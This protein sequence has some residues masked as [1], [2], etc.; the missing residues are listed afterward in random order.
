MIRSTGPPRAPQ[1]ESNSNA[2]EKHGD[3]LQLNLGR[4]LPPLANNAVDIQFCLAFFVEHPK[5]CFGYPKN[6]LHVRNLSLT[7][8]F[9][10]NSDASFRHRFQSI[11]RNET[12]TNGYEPSETNEAKRT[13]GGVCAR[14]AKRPRIGGFTCPS[15]CFVCFVSFLDIQRNAGHTLELS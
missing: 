10:S 2:K 8:E 7:F 12:K 6:V 9:K 13:I 15:F 4:P 3:S 1:F 5:N 11:D 14:G